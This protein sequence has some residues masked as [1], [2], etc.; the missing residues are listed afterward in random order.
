VQSTSSTGEPKAGVAA[1]LTVAEIIERRLM[2]TLFQPIVELRSNEIVGYEALV[3]GPEGSQFES[4]AA[5][6]G[7]A[8]A[9]GLDVELDWACRA[10]ALR[11]ALVARVHPTRPVYINVGPA[12][13]TRPTP[14]WLAEI[15]EVASSQLTIVLEISER[16]ITGAPSSLLA[17]TARL[18][19][20]GALLAL[21]DVGV[22]PR[23]L[24][25][26]PFVDP[27]VVK[28]DLDVTQTR[29]LGRTARMAAA[30]HAH[31]E[32]SGARV[33]AEGIE[34]SEHRD[35]A[36][37]LGADLGQGWLFGHPEPL[38]AEA[39]EPISSAQLVSRRLDVRSAETPFEMLS[40]RRPTRPGTK[41]LLLRMSR[42][43][44][45]QAAAEGEAMVLLSSFQEAEFFG[46][47]TRA[48]YRRLAEHSALVGAL[49]VGLDNTPEPGV[50]GASLWRSEPL[51]GEWNVCAVGP[52]LAAAFVARD[53]GD[54]GPDHLRRFDFIMTHDRELV[55]A[56]TRALMV[57][58]A[59]ESGA[60]APAD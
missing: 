42:G 11:A 46:P 32:R 34:T 13:L 16:G 38:P 29:A 9:A 5:L 2:H 23:S 35:T 36:L 44:E 51:R 18:R 26:L 24:A 55:I 53:L 59:D 40:M 10:T 31:A 15:I 47:A 57:R 14:D 33:L 37:A 17:A 50:R 39:A 19:S 58:L 3:R 7:A 21:D 25:L 22:D 41:E 54:S 30:V 12:S 27:E 49:G 28:L 60:A 8:E 20:Q 43:I 6:F 4:P 1:E 48:R 45:S 56:A 52:Y